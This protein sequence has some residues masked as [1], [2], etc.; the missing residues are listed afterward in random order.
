MFGLN[1]NAWFSLV[2]EWIYA[3]P[4]PPKRKRT[5]P[6]EVLCVGLPCFGTKWF[7]LLSGD[8]KITATD[9]DAVLGYLVAVA[10][11]A[12]SV[13]AAEP[14]AAYPNAKVILNYREDIDA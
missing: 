8:N 10:D 11:T 5:K 6:M 12:G 2:L 7:G 1:L 4:E 13:F 14:I 9:F 3:L